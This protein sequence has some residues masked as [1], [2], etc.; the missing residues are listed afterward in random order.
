V[1]QFQ[2]VVRGSGLI[3]K[4]EV[5]PLTVHFA[6]AYTGYGPTHAGEQGLD[7]L[8]FRLGVDAGAAYLPESRDAMKPV[9]RQYVRAAAPWRGAFIHVLGGVTISGTYID[10]QVRQW[11]AVVKEAGIKGQ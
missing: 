2:V 8:V 7:Y 11:Q 6:A 1:D 10:A 9:P 5:A 3:G 4:H